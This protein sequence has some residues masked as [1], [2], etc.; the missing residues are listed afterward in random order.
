V[1]LNELALQYRYSRHR[2]P[3][4]R[5]CARGRKSHHASDE[6]KDWAKGEKK[7]CISRVFDWL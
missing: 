3:A 1:I 6:R 4:P 5:K 7:S 2:R